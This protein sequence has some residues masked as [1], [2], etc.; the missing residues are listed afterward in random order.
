M[1]CIPLL[2]LSFLFASCFDPVNNYYPVSTQ[3][4]LGNKPVYGEYSEAIKIS[5]E[6][7]K[8]PI[9]YP[10]NIYAFQN[11]VFQVDVGHGIHVIDNSQPSGADR[12]GFI[13]I[14][15]CQQISVKGTYLYTNSYK[16][17]VTLD[18]SIPAHLRVVSRIPNAFPDFSAEPEESGYFECPNAD[19][20][21]V[22]WVQDSVTMN[23]YKN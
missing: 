5:Y 17:L 6:P 20:V 12:I 22:G 18:I 1:K 14:N 23:C 10:G 15:G 11:F 4:V 9:L 8:H 21:V 19:S 3:K 7:E 2:S 13:R 16:D